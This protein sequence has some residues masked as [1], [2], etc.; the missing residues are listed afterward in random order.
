[1]K[2]SQIPKNGIYMMLVAKLAY[3]NR[4]E[5]AA[6]IHKY[7]DKSTALCRNSQFSRIYSVNSLVVE[8][9]S[10]AVEV[11]VAAGTSPG[12]PRIS[13]IVSMSPLRTCTRAKPPSSRSH[14]T[15]SV[16]SVKERVAKTVLSVLVTLAMVVA[17]RSPCAR[18]DQ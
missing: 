16:P 12:K 9:G 13:F 7:D 6:W 18:W 5:W 8:A 4:E 11:E 1:M 14:V 10:L 15:S 3:L 2:F 17:S